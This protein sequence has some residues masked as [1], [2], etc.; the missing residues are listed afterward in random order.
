MKE[1]KCPGLDLPLQLLSG[2]RRGR[3]SGGAPGL[4]MCNNIVYKSRGLPPTEK[5]GILWHKKELILM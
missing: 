2:F 4:V 1:A 3:C 5:S